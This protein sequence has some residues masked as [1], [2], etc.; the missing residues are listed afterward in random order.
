MRYPT[1]KA[2]LVAALLAAIAL[3]TAVVAVLVY[4]C[5][6]VPVKTSKPTLTTKTEAPLPQPEVPAVAKEDPTAGWSASTREAFALLPQKPEAKTQALELDGDRHVFMNGVEDRDGYTET[7]VWFVADGVKR[8]LATGTTDLCSGY[9]VDKTADGFSVKR[10]DSPCE[11]MAT[12]HVEYFSSE[13]EKLGS[14]WHSSPEY[15]F[16]VSWGGR[17]HTV[18]LVYRGSACEDLMDK[19][20]FSSVDVKA[21]KID[22]IGV[23]VD[24]KKYPLPK[25]QSL[26][27]EPA[28]GDA[29]VDPT[30]G[31]IDYLGQGR[32]SVGVGF[33]QKV[34]TL[35]LLGPK[36]VVFGV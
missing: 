31:D 30:F 11:A 1:K 26:S 23:E 20:I 32:F 13:G 10:V 25:P 7:E 29:V 17:D 18:S 21:A 34:F 5:L 22:F 27:C 35:D 15:A 16:S 33:Q 8:L 19:G 6:E 2:A 28:Y 14:L 9:S 24:G 12:V 36:R 4:P 3:E